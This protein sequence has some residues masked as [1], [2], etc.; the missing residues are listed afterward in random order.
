MIEN[1][2][3]DGSDVWVMREY[4]SRDLWCKMF[5]VAQLCVV[6]LMKFLK[7]LGYSRNGDKVLCDQDSKKLC[8]LS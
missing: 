2:G 8:E 3:N 4:V 7:P 5:T 1:R 6:K